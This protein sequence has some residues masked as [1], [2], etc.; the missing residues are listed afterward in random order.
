MSERIN[1][2]R[3]WSDGRARR[4]SITDSAAEAATVLPA[5]RRLEA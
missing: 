1:A 3:R 2:L 5:S 4:A